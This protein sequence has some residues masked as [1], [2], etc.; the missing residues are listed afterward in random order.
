MG[1][2][3]TCSDCGEEKTLFS[4]TLCA[5]CAQKRGA[6]KRAANNLKKAQAGPPRPPTPTPATKPENPPK[7]ESS[8]KILFSTPIISDAD[9]D[10]DTDADIDDPPEESENEPTGNI[11]TIGI[12]IAIPLGILIM[13]Y[14]ALKWLNPFREAT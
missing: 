8:G 7:E 13:G 4:G 3:G 14:F 10:A 12:L 1:R 6:Q 5:S 9:T 2:I 11:S